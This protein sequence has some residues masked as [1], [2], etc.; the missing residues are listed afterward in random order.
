MIAGY[1]LLAFRDPN[2]IRPLILGRNETLA[3][4]EWVAASESVAV[5]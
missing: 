4:T 2:G 5:D 3:G 1:G